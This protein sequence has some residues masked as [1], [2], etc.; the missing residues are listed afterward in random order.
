MNLELLKLSIDI[1][2]EDSIKQP[3]CRF[4]SKTSRIGHSARVKINLSRLFMDYRWSYLRLAAILLAIAFPGLTHAGLR[5]D[6]PPR[7]DPFTGIMDRSKLTTASPTSLSPIHDKRLAVI[8]SDNTEKH[9]KW[10]NDVIGGVSGP[11][12]FFKGLFGGQKAISDSDRLH[13]DTYGPEAIVYSVVE[14]L[15][16]K[17]KAVEI[18]QDL[19]E[20]RSGNFDLLVLMDVTFVNTFRDGFFIGTKY[21]SG[22]YI[23]AFVINRANTLLASITVGE[24]RPVERSRF[25][26][27]AGDIRREMIARYQ[28]EID[29]LLGPDRQAAEKPGAA[30]P[31][32][33]PAMKKS[34][35]DRLLEVDDLLK[36]GLIKPNEAEA[37]RRKILDEI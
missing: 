35:A 14:P 21:E 24:T 12:R 30:N 2:K 9:L 25:L 31:S 3:N 28:V 19:S 10:S 29:K 33:V 37:Q 16:R 32:S 18:I 36:K 34:T 15:V 27:E 5:D 7:N 22:T 1:Y 17:A 11:D 13:K 6:A 4:F 20:F 23:N 8:L 26:F